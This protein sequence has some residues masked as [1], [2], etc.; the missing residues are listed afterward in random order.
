MAGFHHEALFYSDAR[1][2]LGGT[3]AF[4]REGVEAG[5]P[6]MVALPEPNAGRLKWALGHA[7][8]KVMWIDMLA[9]GR[10]PACIIPAWR[11]FVDTLGSAGQAVRGIGEPAWAG[12][13]DEECVECGHHE[14]LLNLAFEDAEAFRLL[15]PYDASKLPGDVLVEARRNHPWIT[16]D[17]PCGDYLNPRGRSGPFTGE[18]APLGTPLGRLEFT[19]RN[20][21]AARVFAAAR[22]HAEGMDRH[23]VLDLVVAVSE[24]AANSIVH[25]GGHGEVLAW[26]HDGTFICEV[27]DRGRIADPLA[28]RVVPGDDIGNGRG[29]WLVNQLCDLVQIRSGA[30]GT[31]VRLHMAIDELP[32]TG[33]E[34][35]A[36]DGGAVIGAWPAEDD[37]PV[38]EPRLAGDVEN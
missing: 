8:E 14:S 17:G 35:G 30:D 21:S 1:E 9:L 18:L 3:V 33:G 7:A 26:R 32:T 37:G 29:L 4:V 2:F 27:R 11:E 10:N 13:N 25:G 36:Q 22:S 15:C 20:L 24:L 23:R 38:V 16:H 34:E 28:G 6:V 5:E 19:R 12:R 31:T